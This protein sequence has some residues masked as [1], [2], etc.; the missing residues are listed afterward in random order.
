[1]LRVTAKPVLAWR[2][3]ELQLDEEGREGGGNRLGRK[4]RTKE[5]PGGGEEWSQGSSWGDSTGWDGSSA[6]ML[7]GDG[8]TWVEGFCDPG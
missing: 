4:G 2:N 5:G 3:T 8:R 6:G 1:M 7:I